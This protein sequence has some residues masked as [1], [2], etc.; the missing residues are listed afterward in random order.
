MQYYSKLIESFLSWNSKINLSAIRDEN[1]VKIKHIK[2]S[3]V[4]KPILKELNLEENKDFV[5]V[6]TGSWFPILPLAMEYK[7]NHF[8]WIESVNKKV[9]AVNNIIK[10]LDLKNVEIIW[11]RAEDE[12]VKKFDVL[13]VRAVSYIDKLLKFTYH[14]VKDWGYFIFYKLDSPWEYEDLL[15]NCKRY[16]LEIIK[17]Y[18]YTLFEN[19]VWRV[20]YILKKE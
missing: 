17:E 13:T 14:L 4:V 15:K 10:A 11:K 5:D 9:N 12:K 18:K 1:Q 7:K 19:D 2:D 20:I 3:L 8:I 16:N 6:G